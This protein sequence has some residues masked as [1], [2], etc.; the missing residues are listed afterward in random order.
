MERW[1]EQA[2]R[3]RVARHRL[4]DPLEVGLLHRQ[5]VLEG[6]TSLGLGGGEDHLLDV[7]EPILRH[8]HVLGAAQPDSLGAELARLRRV[9]GRVGV[10]ANPQPA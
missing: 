3:H 4:E 6:G 9:L 7:W 10:G 5:Q 2:D 8:E 1:V